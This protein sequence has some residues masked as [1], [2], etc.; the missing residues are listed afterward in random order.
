M[1]EG[2]KYVLEDT[3]GLL[4]ALTKFPETYL[5][6]EDDYAITD[7]TGI[8]IQINM[9]DV[10]TPIVVCMDWRQAKAVIKTLKMAIRDERR[11]RHR[12]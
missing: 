6:P 9:V 8:G 2:R 3:A 4:V 1:L 5:H 12:R 10:E 11:R 7:E